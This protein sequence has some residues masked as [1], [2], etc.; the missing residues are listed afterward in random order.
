[1]ETPSF[2][3]VVQSLLEALPQR[4]RIARL[5]SQQL[6]RCCERK[7][8]PA[9]L[10]IFQVP[11]IAWWLWGCGLVGF[12]RGFRLPAHRLAPNPPG[13]GVQGVKIARTVSQQPEEV[14]R[15][16]GTSTPGL[17]IWFE[18][19]ELVELAIR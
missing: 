14:K 18:L 17:S 1:M 12:T 16:G 2:V 10:A 19:R 7:G 15:K 3:E 8:V 4:R 11:R 13:V 5:H 9:T 6:F